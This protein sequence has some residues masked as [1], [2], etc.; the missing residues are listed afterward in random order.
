MNSPIDTEGD[1]KKQV[2][3]LQVTVTN[4]QSTVKIFKDMMEKMLKENNNLGE[5]EK[6][7]I[8]KSIK[9]TNVCDNDVTNQTEVET[10]GETDE[11]QPEVDT[12]VDIHSNSNNA[13][14]KRKANKNKRQGKNQCGRKRTYGDRND[15]IVVVN[16]VLKMNMEYCGGKNWK[17]SDLQCHEKTLMQCVNNNRV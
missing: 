14:P 1:L 7:T 11:V 17:R 15:P 12:E 5:N 16:G 8:Q 3:Q 2:Q 10:E 9:G 4:L 13:V 6:E